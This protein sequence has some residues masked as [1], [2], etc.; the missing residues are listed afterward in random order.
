MNTSMPIKSHTSLPKVLLN[1]F[2]ENCVFDKDNKQVPL[3]S[4]ISVDE[5]AEL[6]R[7]IRDLKPSV[8]AEVGF[9]QGIS[10][11]AILQ[12]LEDNGAGI[13]HV[14]DPFQEKFEDVG[15]AMVERA[16]LSSRMQFHRQFADEVIPNLPELDFGFIDSS[17]LFDLTV[18]EFV[19]MDR[20]LRV[21]GLIAFHDMWMPSLQKFLRYVLSNRSYEIERSFMP[22]AD[23]KPAGSTSGLKGLL[24]KSIQILP[25]RE[26]FFNENILTPWNSLNIPNLV[27]LRKTGLDKRDWQFHR[28][29]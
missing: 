11:L 5:A 14:I 17:H 28:P 13:H 8:S 22:K 4:N 27:I 7:A 6:N 3:H 9:A 25:G 29:F 20:K 19:M 23:M 21:G 2:Q 26:R 1:A 24:L 15:L 18:S 16:G 12:G 10:T